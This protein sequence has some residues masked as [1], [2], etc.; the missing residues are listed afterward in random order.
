MFSIATAP[1]QVIFGGFAALIAALLWAVAAIIFRRL[2]E[3]IPPGELNLIKG[4]LAVLLMIATTLILNE[5][6][7]VM[8]TLTFILLLI[9]GI[10]GI[11]IGDTAY[12]ESL[13]YMGS[14]LALLLGMIAPPLT[15]ILA[16]LF[17][18]ETISLVGWLGIAITIGGVAWVITEEQSAENKIKINYKQ[19]L[20]F[21][22]I[23]SLSQAIGAVISRYAMTEQGVTV[24]A[25]QTAII[26]LLAGIVYLIIF[27]ALSKK[28]PFLWLRKDEHGS[29]ISS[30]KLVRM[31]ALVG[32]I[33]TYSAIWL[34]QVSIQYAPV[35]I[36]QTLL[37]T[38][39]L[40]I[41]P[42]IAIRGEKLSIRAVVG[43]V[44]GLAGIVLLF[45]LG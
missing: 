35:A 14:R 42:I 43:A 4:S 30:W 33:G 11:G 8:P 13:N 20:K 40:F 21:A 10:V 26:R 29:W 5:A 36:A 15:G 16:W 6:L 34:Q 31:V 39:P 1:S 2:G 37:S 12:F 24:S 9:S 23:A 17:F 22:V 45:S 18:R 7:P 3:N 41:L 19:G 28:T 32:F 38:S 25:L 44:I 27:I